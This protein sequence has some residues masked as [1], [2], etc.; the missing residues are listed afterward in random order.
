LLPRNI[1]SREPSGAKIERNKIIIK[2][3]GD[4]G[5]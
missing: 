4:H 5:S 2:F 1:A 3:G